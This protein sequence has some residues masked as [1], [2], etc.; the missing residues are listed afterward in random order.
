MKT[1]HIC[2]AIAAAIAATA[3]IGA[4]S[5]KKSTIT[6]LVPLRP[7]LEEIKKPDADTSEVAYVATRC[8]ALYAAMAFYLEDNNKDKKSEIEKTMLRFQNDSVTFL[9]VSK[10][11]ELLLLNKSE[12]TLKK[13]Q[14]LLIDI[15]SDE[16][17]KGKLLNNNAVT[18]AIEEDLKCCNSVLS[19]Y[20]ELLENIGKDKN[21]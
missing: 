10:I 11:L 6:D 14:K 21:E 7:K 4:D 5:Q 3:L 1:S 12:E 15:Y 13:Q 19:A 16:I 20:Q 8:T 17:A 2:T 9:K 18:P